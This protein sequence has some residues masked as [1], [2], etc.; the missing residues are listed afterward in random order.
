MVEDD[1]DNVGDNDVK[2][3]HSFCNVCRLRRLK[4][5]ATFEDDSDNEVDLPSFATQE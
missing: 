5:H 2:W 3:S 4:L 1:G